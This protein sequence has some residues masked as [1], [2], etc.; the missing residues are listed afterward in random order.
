MG[1]KFIPIFP[2]QG[3]QHPGMGKEFYKHFPSIFNALFEEASEI[4]QI[5]LKKLCFETLDDSLNHTEN[6]QPVLLTL[7]TAIFQVIQK[8]FGW[9]ADF[10]AGHSLGEYAALVAAQSISFQSAI[11]WVKERGKAMQT[12]VPLGEG[13]M[14]AILNLNTDQVEELCQKA[15]LMSQKNRKTASFQFQIPALVSP[16]NYNAP[17]QTVIS[18]SM[19]A[20]QEAKKL[21]QN[22]SEY[23]KA[24]WI[25]LQVSGPFHCQLMEPVKLKI[26]D[27]FSQLREEEKPITPRCPYVPNYTAIPTQEASMI[28]PYLTQQV[29]APVLWLQTVQKFLELENVV[30]IEVGPQEVLSR[31]MKRMVPKNQS[32]PQWINMNQIEGLK[33]LET[34]LS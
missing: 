11:S 24:R 6:A 15:S 16:A 7:C 23:Q 30:F 8:E 26:S 5:D 12:A 19:D 32:F 22:T 27:L 17:D 33:N 29:T 14:V 34:L 25:P 13:G 2:G 4:T 18:G 9:I 31:L 20:L 21:I 28:L 1:L 3:I 10:I